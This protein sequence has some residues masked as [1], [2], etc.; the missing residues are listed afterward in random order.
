MKNKIFFTN[1]FAAAIKKQKDSTLEKK[2]IIIDN[3]HS[4]NDS[5]SYSDQM[6][7]QITPFYESANTSFP[8]QIITTALEDE[9][10]GEN[11]EGENHN[12]Y[13]QTEEKLHSSLKL[14]QVIVT[15]PPS[16]IAHSVSVPNSSSLPKKGNNDLIYQEVQIVK[17]ML[18]FDEQDFRQKCHALNTELNKHIKGKLKIFSPFSLLFLF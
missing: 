18:G 5:S 2:E 12:Q 4:L 7:R 3:N 10:E 15:H 13:S 14:Q 11:I 6:D 16:P 17:K 1:D 9:E 8:E